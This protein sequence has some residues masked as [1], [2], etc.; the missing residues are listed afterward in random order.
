MGHW[1]PAQAHVLFWGTMSFQSQSPR[2]WLNSYFVSKPYPTWDA[3]PSS[4]SLSHLPVLNGY[5]WLNVLW[6]LCGV[7]WPLFYPIIMTTAFCVHLTIS[8]WLSAFTITMTKVYFISQV[9]FYGNNIMNHFI[10]DVSPT[11]KLSCMDLS[12]AEMVDFVLVIVILVFPLSTTVI[13]LCL[14]C[15]FLHIPSAT[16]QQKAFFTYAS[17]LAVVAISCT[18]LIFICL[19]SGHCFI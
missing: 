13:F 15:L 11:F 5:S 18:A 9:A 6:Q 1:I 4:V 3:W 19:T 12:M 10:C 14:H 8:S 16:G 7:C 2:C 17:N